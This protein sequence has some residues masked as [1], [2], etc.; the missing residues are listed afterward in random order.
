MNPALP[1]RRDWVKGR[2]GTNPAL[3]KSDGKR[4]KGR[5]G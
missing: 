5:A 2:T 4:Q 1:M 3:P